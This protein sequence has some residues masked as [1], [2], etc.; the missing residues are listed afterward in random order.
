MRT[1]VDTSWVARP[2][3]TVALALLFQ[4][5][6]RAENIEASTEANAATSAFEFQT[7]LVD[8]ELDTGTVLRLPFDQPFTLKFSM[9]GLGFGD[10]EP[11]L[12]F[13]AF[14]KQLTSLPEKVCEEGN[15]AHFAG[16][17]EE[18][19]T[20]GKT[21]TKSRF[22]L[23]ALDPNRYLVFCFRTTA[24]IAADLNEGERSAL[25]TD[26]KDA[27]QTV[28]TELEVRDAE[29]LVPDLRSALESAVLKY[30]KR[31]GLVGNVKLSGAFSTEAVL[32]KL[33]QDRLAI[34]QCDAEDIERRFRNLI[35]LFPDGDDK[36]EL[37]K[38]VDEA[39]ATARASD[40]QR[41]GE[42]A[43]LS[44]Y[45]DAVARVGRTTFEN[46][47]TGRT[48]LE[49][50]N[51]D[52]SKLQAPAHAY[53]TESIKAMQTKDSLIL[54]TTLAGSSAARRYVSADTG[55]A[56]VPELDSAVSYMGANIY[57][58]PVNPP[59][60]TPL[61]SGSKGLARRFAIMV[62][63]TLQDDLVRE[64]TAPNGDKIK[65]IDNLTDAGS[66]LLGFGFRIN[67]ALRLGGGAI[68]YKQLETL[69]DQRA[70]TEVSYFFS[71]TLDLDVRSLFTGGPN[72][73]FN[74]GSPA[75]ADEE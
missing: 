48:A 40:P 53:A 39:L 9:T 44:L 30:A 69:L 56:F 31:K 45:N 52:L 2:L 22:L 24:K 32:E 3:A 58:R 7:G 35:P 42:A 16:L 47:D 23:P 51:R 63:F 57:L 46:P 66:V 37:K 18:T 15:P 61:G 6:S 68:A 10:T 43:C 28:E 4:P 65:T 26:I 25:L 21:V 13:K 67:P 62:G 14:K 1:I 60:V 38:N 70:S 27:L 29:L 75:S 20:G 19:E 55:F 12:R 71:L 34:S 54:A 49:N 33:R 50:L 64:E 36:T 74:G 41:L 11:T 17:S 73:L 59:S 5:A 8:A 72:G